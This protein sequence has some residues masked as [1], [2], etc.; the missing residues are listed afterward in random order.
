MS[1]FA[2]AVLAIT[3]FAGMACAFVS[4]ARAAAAVCDVAACIN[5]KC[6]RATGSNSQR[7]NSNCQIDIAENKKKRLC[8]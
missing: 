6:K 2:F 4:E 5:T 7:C 1:R 8:K 3:L